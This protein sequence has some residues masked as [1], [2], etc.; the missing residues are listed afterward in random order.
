MAETILPWAGERV[1][2]IGAGAGNM[3]RELSRR[4]RRYVATDID[5]EYLA[6]LRNA[7]GHR[8]TIQIA[9]LDATKAE[10][11]EPFQEQFDTVVCLNV[12]EH[13][14]DD[15]GTLRRIHSLLQPGGKLLLLVPNGPEAYGTLD[16]A[17]GHYRRYTPA[18]LGEVVKSAGFEM[19]EMLTFNRVSWPA[20]RFTGQV[21][22]AT[23]LSPM[24]M[25]TFDRLVWLWRR[26]DK[27]LPWQPTSVIAVAR[28]AS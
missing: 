18:T 12:L 5:A 9:S 22:K 19:D 21:L 10:H 15:L 1:L 6:Q 28:K 7:F 20:W 8:P 26:I 27:S 11:F 17:I 2:E 25:R 13:I 3:T 4:R 23:T 16:A 24:S 14:E